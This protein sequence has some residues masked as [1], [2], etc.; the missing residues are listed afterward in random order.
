MSKDLNFIEED[1][2]RSKEKINFYFFEKIKRI[3]FLLGTLVHSYMYY[4]HLSHPTWTLKSSDLVG[5]AENSVRYVRVIFLIFY[6]S[7]YL[8]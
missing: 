1:R 2:D 4:L 3:T 5:R 8:Q 6:C 7:T